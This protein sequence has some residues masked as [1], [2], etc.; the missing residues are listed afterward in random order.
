[1]ENYLFEVDQLVVK[2][3]SNRLGKVFARKMGGDGNKYLIQW[4]QRSRIPV[5]A[6]GKFRKTW[7][8]EHWLAAAIDVKK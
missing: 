4:W 6:P 3:K 7:V 1:M 8:S 5:E 2:K